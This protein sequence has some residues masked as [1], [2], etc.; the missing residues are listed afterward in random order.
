MARYVIL[1][2]CFILIAMSANAQMQ[3]QTDTTITQ[4][5]RIIPV[6]VATLLKN[7]SVIMNMQYANNSDFQ[8]GKYT[9]TDFAMNQF[10]L[11]IKGQVFDNVFF[12]F[13]DRYTRDPITQS[14][15][16]INHSIDLAFIGID[17]SPEISLAFGK[18][19]AD[20]GGY[21]FDANPID[22]YQYN[23]IVEYA[24]N[25]L[26]G[27]QLTWTASKDHQFAFQILNARTQTYAEIYDTIPGV[28]AAKFPAALV[29]NWRGSFADGEFATFWSY[30]LIKEASNKNVYY[31]ALGNQFNSGNWSVQY[32][33]KYMSDEIDRLGLVTSLIPQSYSQ[34]TALN[35]AYIEHWLR[36]EYTLDTQWKAA[37]IGMVSDAYWHGNPDPNKDDHLRTA[38]GII[39]SVEYYPYKGLNLKFFTSY[40][41]RYYNYTDY[42]KSEFGLENSTNG[43]IMIGFISPLV[44]L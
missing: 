9:G 32:D 2:S 24:D 17:V 20:Y 21:E 42:A 33:F 23:D 3:K 43:T 35:T 4:T 41:G 36:V 40:V 11:E 44:V 19:C 30:S 37:I 5:V 1:L 22:I 15:D 8:D 39:P 7:M 27:A 13:R 31:T 12:R 10:R 38:W 14:V 16:N 25:F 28:T 18:M 6:D 29:G 34:Y 26:T